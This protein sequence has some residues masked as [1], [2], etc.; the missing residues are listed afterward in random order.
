MP[1]GAYN[2]Y[3][4]YRYLHKMRVSASVLCVWGGIWHK[5]H[6]S[7]PKPCPQIR[8]GRTLGGQLHGQPR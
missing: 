8:R 5:G 1:T 7:A 3:N 4:A 2:A 6:H